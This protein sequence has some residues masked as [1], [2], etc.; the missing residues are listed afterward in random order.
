MEIGFVGLGKMGGN[1]VERL[2]RG[3]EHSVVAFDR[4]ADVA[5]H[6]AGPA[7][8]VAGSLAELVSMLQPPRAVWLMVPA[9]DPV[10]QSIAEL[11]AVMQPG[12]IVID[13]GNSYFRD[14]QRRAAELKPKAINFVDVGTSGGI[15]GLTVGYCLMIG[16]DQA[17]YDHLKPIF[18]TL[19]P[20]DGEAYM[21]PCG[22]GHFVKMVHNGI[23]Y[24]IMQ[25]YAEG[26]GVLKKSEFNLDLPAIGG[27]WQHGSVVRSWLL[28]LA[29]DALQKSPNLDGIK[30][31][32]VDSGEGRW[33]VQ[34]GMDED[35]PTPVIALSLMARFQSRDPDSF[36]N[37]LLAA[38]RNQFGGHAIEHEG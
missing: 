19:A 24:G 25:S 28:D 27:V 3:G 9:G 21:G 4:S 31:Y 23:E 6:L 12:D 5:Q 11:S 7:V 33:T 13:G 29:T 15:W 38:L 37:K 18:V 16:C 17:I 2:T 34:A 1:M 22:S 14:S 20:D 8:R 26:F 10:D 30:G 36:Q 32:V 35:V